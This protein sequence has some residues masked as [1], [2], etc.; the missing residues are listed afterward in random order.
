MALPLS[1]S[2]SD[3]DG[4]LGLVLEL[5]AI[6]TPGVRVLHNATTTILGEESEPQPDLGLRVRPEFVGKPG[7]CN[8]RPPATE[9]AAAGRAQTPDVI[10]RWECAGIA[11]CAR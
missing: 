4:K 2:H 3:Y 9:A 7:A 5:Y 8:V 11:T 10:K 6:V 1:E